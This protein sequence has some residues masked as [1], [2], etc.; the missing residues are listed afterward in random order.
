MDKIALS[1]ARDYFE[2]VLKPSY[3]RFFEEASSFQNAYAMVN[4]LFHFNEWVWAYEEAKLKT[5]YSDSSKSKFWHEIVEKEVP[6]AGLIRDLCNASKH[7]KLKIKYRPSTN[8]RHSANTRITCLG[9]GEG[10]FGEGRYGGGNVTMNVDN[11][12]VLLDVVA[13]ELF[14]FWETLVDQVDPKPA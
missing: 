3:D 5:K 4:S 7:V 10:G 12:E 13:K 2:K 9:W 6:D 1:G 8:M 14:T 11:R